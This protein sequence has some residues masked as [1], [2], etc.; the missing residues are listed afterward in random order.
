MSLWLPMECGEKVT[1]MLTPFLS[2]SGLSSADIT[3]I[4]NVGPKEAVAESRAQGE[5]TSLQK[6]AIPIT[7]STPST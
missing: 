6:N 4:F 5:V 1:P 7:K 3:E 2:G